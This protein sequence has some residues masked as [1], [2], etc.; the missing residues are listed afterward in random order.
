MLITGEPLL[1]LSPVQSLFS[2]CVKEKALIFQ[3]LWSN[4]KIEMGSEA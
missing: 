4:R 1:S 3:I 2:S